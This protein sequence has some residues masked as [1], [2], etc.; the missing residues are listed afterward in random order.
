M[1]APQAKKKKTGRAMSDRE[2]WNDTIVN[3][4]LS[5]KT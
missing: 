2:T 4:D 1:N 5:K 3:L